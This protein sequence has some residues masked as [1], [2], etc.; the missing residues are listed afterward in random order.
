MVGG[1]YLLC[2]DLIV[3]ERHVSTNIEPRQNAGGTC[4]FNNFC[5]RNISFVQQPVPRTVDLTATARSR[6]V[7]VTWAGPAHS[8]TPGIALRLAEK[9][10]YFKRGQSMRISAQSS[11]ILQ[12]FLIGQ[13]TNWKKKLISM[14]LKHEYQAKNL[15]NSFVTKSLSH[16]PIQ[17]RIV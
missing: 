5:K 4:L 2:N 12:T 3:N 1:S 13:F 7:P 9:R 17:K 14:R 8:A 10:R 11:Y 16:P 15:K 6:A